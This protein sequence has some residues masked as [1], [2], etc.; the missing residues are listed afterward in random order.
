MMA[1]SVLGI[2]IVKAMPSVSKVAN[3]TVTG[4]TLINLQRKTFYADGLHW[5]FYSD[6]TNGI[7]KTSSDG[8]TWSDGQS[9]PFRSGITL[10]HHFDTDF[11]GTHIAYVYASGGV[12]APCYFRTGVTN[13][14]GGITWSAAEQTVAST[15]NIIS[16]PC[17]TFDSSGYP[18]VAYVAGV[19]AASYYPNATKSSSNDGTWTTQSGF[20]VILNSTSAF[21][22]RVSIGCLSTG[23]KVYIAYNK[24]GSGSRAFGK[25]WNG[26]AFESE[27]T[28]TS[29]A[30]YTAESFSMGRCGA[31][32]VRF[33]YLNRT[34]W[35]KYVE[36]NP[37]WGSTEQIIRTALTTTRF[38]LSVESSTGTTYCFFGNDTNDQVLY[39]K[40]V[41]GVWDTTPTFLFYAQNIMLSS[42]TSFKRDFSSYIGVS[43][44]NGSSSSFTVLYDFLTISAAT[45]AYTRSGLSFSFGVHKSILEG[46][47]TRSSLNF[48]S[49]IDYL[50]VNSYSSYNWAPYNWTTYGT[51]PYLS[52]DDSI[53]CVGTI[54]SSVYVGRFGFV[55]TIMGTI[56]SVTL[57]VKA[58]M[59]V[60][61]DYIQ[62]FKDIGTYMGNINPSVGAYAWYSLSLTSYY[63]TTSAVNS[64]SMDFGKIG[65]NGRICI[66]CA[67][68]YITGTTH[69][70]SKTSEGIFPRSHLSFVWSLGEIIT[71]GIKNV[72]HTSFSTT[73][74]D[75]LSVGI[76]TAP[77][78]KFNFLA[79]TAFT[80]SAITATIINFLSWGV[81]IH[82]H[83]TSS[84]PE[85]VVFGTFAAGLILALIF[86][87]LFILGYTI[88]FKRRW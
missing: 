76:N 18:W 43:C 69:V 46:V 37:T 49:V 50:L 4:S 51:S 56:T 22:W 10:G 17:I 86:V 20:P 42:I 68:L 31:D 67:Y 55:D 52:D 80:A 1:L 29:E 33:A 73:I 14:T 83:T 15:S 59:T 28:I 84:V 81:S 27:E 12:G 44:T 66:T 26:T 38:S 64:A 6:G 71:A 24:G 11:N 41:N 35:I 39:K 82:T 9:S 87:I 40:R 30:V 53:N 2:P 34:Y 78:I 65:S 54:G 85:V 21:A 3:T 48:P 36:R 61:G 45:Q 32:I 5:V 7:Y 19:G 8:T 16:V 74:R 58:N 57:Y 88:F 70:R 62:V 75:V 63:T 79:H 60:A 25:L 72:A 47:N 23:N 77:H 13:T